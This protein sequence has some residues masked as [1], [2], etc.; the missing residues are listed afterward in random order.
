MLLTNKGDCCFV[1]KKKVRQ[2][3]I[4]EIFE[5]AKEAVRLIQIFEN[6]IKNK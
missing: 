4:Q 3:A 5:E 6:G 1:S 2:L